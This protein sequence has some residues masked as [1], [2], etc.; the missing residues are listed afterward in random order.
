MK[1]NSKPIK[2]K[3]IIFNK[4]G[5]ILLNKNFLFKSKQIVCYRFIKG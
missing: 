2:L 4:K 5:Q 3:E 1:L